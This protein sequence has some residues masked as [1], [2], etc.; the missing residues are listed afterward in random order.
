MSCPFPIL[1]IVVKTRTLLDKGRFMK[2]SFVKCME[3]MVTET[4]GAAKWK[5]CMD[6]AGIPLVRR[7]FTIL[8]DVE[9]DDV[10]AILKGISA[11][12]S[13]S[14]DQVMDAF[15]EHWSTVFGPRVYAPYFSSA[16]S[17]RELLLNLDHIHDV[18]TKSIKFARPPR[19]TYE[20]KGDKRLIMHYNS[21]RGMVAMMPGLIRGVG[22]YFNEKLRVHV[23]GNAV[24]VDFG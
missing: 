21:N 1:P 17:A 15:G 14:M 20:W 5:T 10:R 4:F 8:S 19:F 23:E 11:A 7:N 2:G 22:K 6:R 24:Y 3:E 16:K 18:M 9:D 12:T 13:L